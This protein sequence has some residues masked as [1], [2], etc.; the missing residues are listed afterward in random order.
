MEPKRQLQKRVHDDFLGKGLDKSLFSA[1]S[2]RNSRRTQVFE[3]F[4]VSAA[5]NV[6]SCFDLRPKKT[7][8]FRGNSRKY[9]ETEGFYWCW[10]AEERD[11]ALETGIC[12]AV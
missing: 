8:E 1:I 10:T 5:E 12:E 11:E 3:G 9:A 4:L 2:W 6:L 7:R